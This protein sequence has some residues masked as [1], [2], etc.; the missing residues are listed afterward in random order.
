MLKDFRV[1]HSKTHTSTLTVCHDSMSHYHDSPI[2][3]PLSLHANRLLPSL[4]A[5]ETYMPRTVQTISP[6]SRP[7]SPRMSNSNLMNPVVPLALQNCSILLFVVSMPFLDENATWTEFRDGSHR[8]FAAR[9][10][11][12]SEFRMGKWIAYWYR[13]PFPR[14]L[15]S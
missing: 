8:H 9:Q 12:V 14:H 4:V 6:S 11:R 1:P 13:L 7:V 10:F 2:T 15:L 3:F 5:S